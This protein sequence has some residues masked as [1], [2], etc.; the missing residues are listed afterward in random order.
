M[1]RIFRRSAIAACALAIAALASAQNTSNVEIDILFP[2][3]ATYNVTDNFP[4]AVAI[5]NIPTA[6]SAEG[7]SLFWAIMPWG[8]S[9]NIP[10][11][12]VFD[13]GYFAT[14][15][16]S[17]GT[18]LLVNSTNSSAWY[19]LDAHEYNRFQLQVHMSWDEAANAFA[20]PGTAGVFAELMFS[21]RWPD[22]GR[23]EGEHPGGPDA[24]SYF[25]AGTG[26]FADGGAVGCPAPGAVARVLPN[27]TIDNCA[28]Q[29]GA[30]GTGIPSLAPTPC[31]VDVSEAE[32]SSLSSKAL[33]IATATSSATSSATES[34]TG[35]AGVVGVPLQ[36]ALAAAWALNYCM[37]A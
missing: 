4:V 16:P 1:T 34:P 22:A 15:D 3:N 12:L 26:T 20:C 33:D 27:R 31:A 10:G 36:P 35:A 5:Q 21:V 28:W 6:L 8:D 25:G 23:W 2:R 24:G 7:L 18:A 37:L 19:D 32:A 9:G 14:P 13:S 30:H 11:G 29:F 17:A